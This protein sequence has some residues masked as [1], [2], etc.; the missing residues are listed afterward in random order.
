[1][2][3]TRALTLLLLLVLAADRAYSNACAETFE[4]I[5]SQ[6]A[7][8]GSDYPKALAAFRLLPPDLVS[9]ERTPNWQDFKQLEDLLKR[10][11][12]LKAQASPQNL[13][14]LEAVLSQ[15]VVD[16]PRDARLAALAE[17]RL[18]HKPTRKYQPTEYELKLLYQFSLGKLNRELPR[19]ARI[20]L[21]RLP[22]DL[23]REK[24]ISEAREFMP[25]LEADFERRFSTTG[26]ESFAKFEVAIRK[27]DDPSIKRALDLI[28]GDQIEVVIRRPEEG[29]FWIPKVGFQNQHVTGSSKGLNS[30]VF[31]RRSEARLYAIDD[32]AHSNSAIDPF[33]NLDRE[34]LPKYGTLRAKSETGVKFKGDLTKNYGDDLYVL[35]LNNIKDRLS[36][37]AGD[38]LLRGGRTGPIVDWDATFAPWKYRLLLAPLMARGLKD[39]NAI[40]EPRADSRYL[41]PSF[42][43]HH[44][45]F[46]ETQILGPLNLKD[47]EAFEFT[48]TPPKGQFLLDLLEHKIRIIDGRVEEKK[49]WIPSRDEVSRAKKEA[50]L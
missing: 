37:T 3:R 7:A 40:G 39:D 27:S 8:L 9:G 34:I 41:T 28:D 17:A 13:K 32:A 29:R 44:L 20:P 50:G 45:S 10:V 18:R 6:L 31:R 14:S 12:G 4:S 16:L 21:Q 48:W 11:R 49:D 26:H 43:I 42:G 38:S 35:R 2:R 22:V 19:A 1:M 33:A 23:R 24:L 36:W 46:W 15:V 47:V 5:D 30:P 25:L